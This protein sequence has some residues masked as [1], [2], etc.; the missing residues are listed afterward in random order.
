MSQVGLLSPVANCWEAL[1][2]P[3]SDRGYVTAVC[4]EMPL[5]NKERRRPPPPVVKGVMLVI[6][7]EVL[8]PAKWQ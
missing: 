8:L 2:A 3:G 6:V 4:T 7:T 1:S 5:V